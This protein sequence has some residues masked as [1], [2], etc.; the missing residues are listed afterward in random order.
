MIE[1][2]KLLDSVIDETSRGVKLSDDSIRSNF[3]KLATALKIL[4][5][6]VSEEEG[7]HR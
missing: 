5:Y 4:A 2:F 1:V 6:K 3:Y 7:D